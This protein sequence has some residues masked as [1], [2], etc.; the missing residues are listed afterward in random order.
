MAKKIVIVIFVILILCMVFALASCNSKEELG[1][2][3]V[4][5]THI[6]ANDTFTSDNISSYLNVDK[7]IHLTD[8][9]I[10]T[11]ADN[12]IASK[13]KFLLLGGDLT[14]KGDLLSHQACVNALSRIESA[15]IGVFVINGNHDIAQSPS[16][17]NKITA[18]KFKELYN[19]F[20]YGQALAT[21]DGTLSYTAD[22]NKKYRLIAID[23]ISYQIDEDN[24]KEALSLQH[25][26]WIISQVD[27]SIADKKTPIIIGHIPLLLHM[28]KI[29][30]AFYDKSYYESCKKL[31]TALADKGCN[32]AFTG[33]LHMQDAISLTTAKGSVFTDVTSS[34]VSFYPASYRSISFKK[35]QVD[36]STVQVSNINDSYLSPQIPE[37]IKTEATTNF[38]EYCYTHLHG[39]ILH[40]VSSRFDIAEMVGI[41]YGEDTFVDV[42]LNKF[43]S[44]P[45]YI[46]DENN[47]VSMERILS[48]YGVQLPAS[49]HKTMVD[50]AVFYVATLMGG[51]QNI[52]NS[53]ENT[54]VKHAAKIL[55]YY[56]NE[57]S[58]SI[59][60]LAPDKGLLNIDLDKL[61]KLGIL[62]CYDSNLIPIAISIFGKNVDNFLI[63]SALN[64]ISDNFDALS[65]YQVAI[66]AFTAGRVANITSYF[67][68]KS[69]R[70]DDLIDAI[71][72]EY[73]AD[74]VLDTAPPDNN[75][76]LTR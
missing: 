47:N 49:K 7:M 34:S 35:K 33:H 61:F 17:T 31:V 63:K 72:N 25:N 11:I 41:D 36:V 68:S 15:G 50:V 10:N 55:F 20:G 28:P 73:L 24:T 22:L 23:N 8:A 52:T 57:Q 76:S 60:K 1:F 30:E 64:S 27:A 67:D 59:A 74:F 21:Y 13:T 37:N 62:E 16:Q 4:T 70:I 58:E 46:K 18:T 39:G 75:F 65:S 69:L 40:T 9:I 32:Y 44:H 54:I 5:D 42:A 14:E 3:F 45:L 53:V 48:G 51:D 71:F 19:D 12:V 56:M 38:R 29:I 6:I 26:E 2:T 43:L 66:D